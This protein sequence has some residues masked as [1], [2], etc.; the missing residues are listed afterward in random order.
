MLKK[1]FFLSFFTISVLFINAQEQ[2]S[3]LYKGLID[4]KMPVTLY[5]QAQ[6]NGCGGDPFY[7]AMYKYD[8]VSKWLQLD[9]S[10]SDKDEYAM[11]EYGFTGLM[12]L[13]KEENT[14]KGTWISPDGK[15]QLPVFLKQ[16]NIN[17]K[18]SET[19]QN[20]LDEVNYENHDC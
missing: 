19:Y 5:L 6:Q 3:F 12:I 7:M 9:I 18:D 16:E 2:Q 13:K 20:K 10:R 14:L 4:R 8:K 11:V 15:R 1:L 17:K